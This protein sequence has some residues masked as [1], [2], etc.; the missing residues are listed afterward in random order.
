MTAEGRR[1]G[2]RSLPL[3]LPRPRP[4]TSK[5]GGSGSAGFTL[6]ELLVVLVLLAV[7][8]ALV[9]PRLPSTE[10]SALKSSARTTAAL[11]RYL[12]ERSQGSKQVYR[13]HVNIA[14]NTIRVTRRMPNGDEL[15]PDDPLLARQVLESGVV[16]ADLQSPRLG[17]VTDGEVLIDF[18]AAGLTEFLTLHLATAKGESFTV[19]GYP[20][21]GKIKLLAG[22]QE[23]TL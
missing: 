3:Q 2:W 5:P 14:E 11:L 8:T 19:A 7:V 16:I 9:V 20:A 6:I 10:S 12:G 13:L 23:L 4:W 15:P 18:G 21:G 22:Y 1:D 17:K